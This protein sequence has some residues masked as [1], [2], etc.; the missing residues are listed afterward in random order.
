MDINTNMS[1]LI[2]Q[3]SLTNTQ[4]AMQGALAKLSSGYRINQASDDAAGYAIMQKMDGQVQGLNQASSNA[5]NAISLTQ[6][7]QGALN[8]TESILQRMRVLAVQ[9]AS[10]TATDSDRQQIQLETNQLAQELSRIS[11]TTEFNTKN[12]LSGAFQN[13]IFQIGANQDQNLSVSIGAM[14]AFSLGVAANSD[15]QLTNTGKSGGGLQGT[16]TIMTTS[17]L[18]IGITYNLTA[19]KN[20]GSI[21]SITYDSTTNGLGAAN[22]K[23]TNTST[24]ATGN[25]TLSVLVS[26][27]GT[28]AGV[29]IRNAQGT[30]LA[31]GTITF[32][33]AAAASGSETVKFNSAS[34]V[35]APTGISLTISGI[36]QPNGSTNKASGTTQSISFSAVGNSLSFKLAGGGQVVDTMSGVSLGVAQT[37][38]LGNS[39]ISFNVKQGTEALSAGTFGIS[40]IQ[41]SGTTS[42]AASVGLN[43]EVKDNA[44]VQFG[45]LMNTQARANNA[46]TIINNAINTVATQL[47]SLGAYQNRL[48]DTVSNLSVTS[49]N[50]TAAEGN[51][52]DVDMAAEMS[53]FT[54]DQVLSQAGVAMLAQANQVPQMI[55]KLLG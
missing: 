2:A 55:L 45:V 25:Y 15:V 20:N 29:T 30:A 11:N 19:A 21:N 49:Q 31:E 38:F 22:I 9:S 28:T 6:T 37:V 4:N 54:Q 16:E 10:D 51:I 53:Q 23:L 27:T 1:S 35:G 39:G 43:G 32:S 48:T 17:P 7:A 8:E 44:T 5:Q 41:V 18:S 14:D 46:I 36:Q 3:Q 34:G 13:Q 52:K 24:L 40:G 50:M 33:T 47:A 26:S 42:A 12:L